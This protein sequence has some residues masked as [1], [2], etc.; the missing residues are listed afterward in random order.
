MKAKCVDDSTPKQI[1]R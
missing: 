1:P